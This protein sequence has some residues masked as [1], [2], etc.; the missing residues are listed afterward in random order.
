MSGSR[1][2][3]TD[4][5]AIQVQSE[6]ESIDEQKKVLCLRRPIRG[7][8]CCSCSTCSFNNRSKLRVDGILQCLN[9]HHLSTHTHTHARTHA[10]THNTVG[11]H[12][13]EKRAAP[14]NKAVVTRR[15]LKQK[16]KKKEAVSYNPFPPPP[17]SPSPT[18]HT[19]KNIP[20]QSHR[21]LA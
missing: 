3:I 17:R 6:A 5:D 18:H 15:S 9:A 11:H 8:V 14:V 7:R 20:V 1:F 19:H 21:Y 2:C 16:Q 12:R 13:Q 4:K 10:H